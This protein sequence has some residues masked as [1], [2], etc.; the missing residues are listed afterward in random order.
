MLNTADLWYRRTYR[1]P[2]NDPRYLETT[3]EERLTEFYAW[4][5]T[6]NPKLLEVVEDE[7]FDLEDIQ[8]QWAEEIGET[9]DIYTPPKP[10]DVDPENVDDWEEV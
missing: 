6:D 10:T 4:Q 2:P 3:L 9:P 7:S 5:Y 1:L 8:R